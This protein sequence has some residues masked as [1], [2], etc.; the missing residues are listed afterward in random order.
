MGVDFGRCSPLYQHFSVNMNSPSLETHPQPARPDNFRREFISLRGS[1]GRGFDEDALVQL[2]V[3]CAKCKVLEQTLPTIRKK[4]YYFRTLPLLRDSY[5]RGCHLC[6]L[7]WES[8]VNRLPRTSSEYQGIQDEIPLELALFPTPEYHTIG[9]SS[10]EL[11]KLRWEM[12]IPRQWSEFC[13]SIHL[14]RSYEDTSDPPTLSASTVSTKAPTSRSFYRKYMEVCDK[15]HTEC[16]VKRAKRL[17]TR[18][19][20]VAPALSGSDTVPSIQLVSPGDEGLEFPVDTKFTALSYCWGRYP[21]LQLK[22]SNYQALTKDVP[23]DGLP[24]TIQDSVQVTIELGLQYL[25]V[26][27][28]CIVQD[29]IKDWTHEAAKMCDVYQGCSITLAASGAEDSNGGLFAVRDP[30]RHASCILSGG[31]RVTW[32]SCEQGRRL[33]S[34]ERPWILETRGWAVQEHLLPPRLIKFGSYITWQCRELSI[35]EFGERPDGH[36]QEISKI[37]P[38]FYSLVLKPE[39]TD[40]VDVPGIRCLWWFILKGYMGTKLSTKRDRLAAISGLSSAIQR[41]TGWT[42]VCGLW[43]PFITQELLWYR[44]R[45]RLDPTGLRPSWSWASYDGG[46]GFPSFY[47]VGW[48]DVAE[49]VGIH[50]SEN[51]HTQVIELSGIMCPVSCSWNLDTEAMQFSGIMCPV[52]GARTGRTKRQCD[53]CY[54][55]EGEVIYD[56]D[57]PEH[58][59]F[60]RILPLGFESFSEICVLMG[61]V[62]VPAGDSRAFERVGYFKASVSSLVP[63]EPLEG[64][65]VVPEKIL[66]I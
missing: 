10:K 9:S 42:L 43:Q 15:T 31:R 32:L 6:S 39:S 56:Q 58:T 46:L 20:R 52:H 30:L 29:S 66:L 64:L 18:L 24:A 7:I 11:Y 50:N 57:D 37:S 12:G 14:L 44:E 63:L 48:T 2:H 21:G 41:R 55:I 61:L 8:L 4:L 53:K 65:V 16:H 25:W 59:Y 3:L 17:P 13:I 38:D 47:S 62:V 33:E 19:L 54:N 35:D 27:A 49:C 34:D 40:P 1:G 28:L 23:F 51:G 36:S 60:H 45:P 5:K 22:T 26:D